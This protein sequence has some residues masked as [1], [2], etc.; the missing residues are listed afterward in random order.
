MVE[1][2]EYIDK[3]GINHFGKWFQ[4]LNA[5]ASA[6]VVTYLSRIKQGNFSSVK[7]VNKGIEENKRG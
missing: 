5:Q 4:G 6:K 7:S 1:I 2:R 3:L